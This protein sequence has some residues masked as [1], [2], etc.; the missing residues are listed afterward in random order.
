MMKKFKGTIIIAVI[1][2]LFLGGYLLLGK[3]E[4][5]E[6][7]VLDEMISDISKEEIKTVD[8]RLEDEEFDIV[9]ENNKWYIKQENKK[10]IGYQKKVDEV[11]RKLA[12]LWSITTI[13]RKEKSLEDFG[14]NKPKY[15]ITIKTD[16]KSKE[17]N[18]GNETPA[19]DS[20]FVVMDDKDLI[21]KVGK[22]R[23]SELIN[24]VDGLRQPQI[25]TGNIEDINK[26][27]LIKQGKKV[28]SLTQDEKWKSE[29][30]LVIDEEKVKEFVD[31]IREIKVAD[32]FPKNEDLELDFYGLDKPSI[33]L[34]VTY[35]DKEEKLILGQSAGAGQVYGI[36]DES[37]WVIAVLHEKVNFFNG[38]T[39]DFFVKE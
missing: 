8:I 6:D 11:I 15:K 39:K 2:V 13:D 36:R 7:D 29:D 22:G 27:E 19:K 16:N 1:F 12:E 37:E 33:V 26:I 28:I 31:N 14:L 9:K 32:V 4:N 34:T 10:Y 35:D 5:V 18:I 38:F 23:F 3:D 21:Y 17:I 25:F 24:G 30:N 20:Y